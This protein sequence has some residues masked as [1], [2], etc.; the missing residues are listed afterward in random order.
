ML[1]NLSFAMGNYFNRNV[2]DLGRIY[3]L[4]ISTAFVSG[5]N[6]QIFMIFIG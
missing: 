6:G 5:V 2:E 1:V 4:Y 3:K